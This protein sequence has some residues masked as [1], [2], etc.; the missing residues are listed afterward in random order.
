MLHNET[1][2]LL[3]QAFEKTHNAK[4]VAKYFSVDRSTV[5]RISERQRKEG[6]VNVK[7]Y[8]RGRKRALS[9][10]NISQIEALVQKQT[11]ITLQEI[12]DKLHLHVCPNTVANAL[13]RLGY[14]W[15]KKSI[16]AKEQDR[17]RCSGQTE[18]LER[19]G[20]WYQSGQ[21]DLS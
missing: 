7:T 2:R 21:H 12:V 20:I 3:E 16:H 11:D 18:R 4:E 8:L 17:P 10:E 14:T 5:Y 6:N 9:S 19:H 15:K 13:R 1:R